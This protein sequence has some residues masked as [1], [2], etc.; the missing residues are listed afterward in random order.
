[1]VGEGFRLLVEMEHEAGDLGL[2][3]HELGVVVQGVSIAR[4]L[5]ADGKLL[6]EGGGGAHGERDDAVGHEHGFVDVVG[7]HD[8]GALVGFPDVED[9]ILD[10]GAG[11]GIEGGEGFVEKQD[12]GVE[13]ERAG[14]GGALAH[15]AG[16]FVGFLVRGVVEFHHLEIVVDLVGAFG[17]REL[18]EDAVDG[19]LD[20]VED[21]EPGEERVILEHQAAVGARPVHGLSVEE[22]LAGGGGL[23]AGEDGHQGGLAGAGEADDGDELVLF[24][25]EVDVLQDMGARGGGAEGDGDG[26]EGE[27]W[28][29]LVGCGAVERSGGRWG[30]GTG[31]DGMDGMR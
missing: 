25:A 18:G 16:E 20:V 23:E 29:V 7:D 21:A 22:G 28:H 19:E 5:H 10:L 11:E 14:E 12:L 2:E 6:G 9:L 8:D 27:G 24:D 3:A 1:M 15:A 17:L 13:R 31:M 30:F 26:V 4:A